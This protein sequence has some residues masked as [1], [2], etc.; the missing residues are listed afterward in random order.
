MKLQKNVLLIIITIFCFLLGLIFFDDASCFFFGIGIIFLAL[1]LRL[2]ILE[3]W[4]K[5]N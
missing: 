4:N 3:Y 5:K 1:T 2:I